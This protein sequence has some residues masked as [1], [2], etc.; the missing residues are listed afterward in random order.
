MKD[1]RELP[2]IGI[3]FDCCGVYQRIYRQP[4]QTAYVGWCPRCLRRVRVRVG[5]GGV[6]QRIFEAR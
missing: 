2:Y 1:H 3:H 5:P 6:D 4:G